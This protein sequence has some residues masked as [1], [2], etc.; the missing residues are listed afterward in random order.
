M[1]ELVQN[2]DD[3]ASVVSDTAH[4][5]EWRECTVVFRLP[6]LRVLALDGWQY[7]TLVVHATWHDT[8]LRPFTVA[9]M[10]SGLA[11]CR[12]TEVDQA[13]TAAEHLLAECPR[14]WSARDVD[15]AAVPAAT[16]QWCRENQ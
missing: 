1:P 14:V 7:G 8:R 12:F 13:K 15:A 10:P 5:P 2:D 16:V 9:H 3:A 4:K 11:L 6:S